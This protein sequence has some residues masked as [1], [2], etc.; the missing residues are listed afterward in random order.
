[1]RSFSALVLVLVVALPA[2]VLAQQEA[3]P[4]T[5][6]PR[7]V[8]RTAP[9]LNGHIFMPSALVDPPFRSTTAK[10]G[11]L[12][13]V[14]TA[15]GPKY[16]SSGQVPGETTD[17][18][19]AA[20]AQTFRYEYQFLDWLS[21]GVAILTSLYS[22]VTGASVVSVG[23][24]IGVGAGLRAR[25]GHRFGPVETA[26][27]IDVAT[28]PEY[29]LLVAA[30]LLRAVNDGVIDPGSALQATHSLTV[31]PALSAAW[32]P[33][34]ALG[35]TVNLGYL[36]K[37]LRLTGGAEVLNQSGIQFSGVVDFDFGKITSTPVGVQAGY[38]I[39][40]PIGSDGI[41]RIE[42]VTAG[43]FYTARREFSLGLELGW[44]SFTIRPPL[45]SSLK[46]AQI[47]LQ[48]YW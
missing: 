26:F 5:S 33:I 27:I 46:L 10:V 3:P 47:E 8:G 4:A 31:N 32:A 44:R 41:S 25:A 48:Y 42:D 19:F 38:R 34:P 14:G 6:E 30:A 17:Y 37:S 15:T 29:G 28:Q 13:G 12:Y 35:L 39:A 24:E 43:V 21:G 23:A 2:A 9:E 18:T 20:M 22:G 36:F 1:M 7:V 40:A 45:D 16:D 11:L